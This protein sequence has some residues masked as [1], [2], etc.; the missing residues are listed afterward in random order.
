MTILY[1]QV[2]I[3]ATITI[4]IT[5]IFILISTFRLNFVNLLENGHKISKKV[6]FRLFNYFNVFL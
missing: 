1:F 4:K 2:Y 6:F 3:Y 5:Q